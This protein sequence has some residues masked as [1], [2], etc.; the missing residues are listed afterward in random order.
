MRVT[1]LGC[2]GSGGVP[3]IGGADGAGDWGACDPNEPRN[4]RTRSSI[5]V[6]NGRTTVLIDTTPDLRYQLLRAQVGDITAVLYTHCHA[7]HIHGI[8]DLRALRRRRG[9]LVDIYGSAPTIADLT[10]RFDYVFAGA[11]PYPPT[12][13]THIHNGPF[14]IGAMRIH[15]F[16]QGHGTETTT[17]YRIGSMA[18][19]TDVVTLDECAFEILEGIEVWIVDCLRVEPHPTHTHFARAMEWIRRVGP[20]QAVLTHLNTSM[21]YRAVLESCPEGVVPAFDGMVIDL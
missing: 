14:S 13:R 17:G 8:D 18:Y 3:V 16:V 11:G 10:R 6:Q 19:S 9:D 21:D 2:G 15:P 1:I 5:L 4:R 12:A 20:R 7:D